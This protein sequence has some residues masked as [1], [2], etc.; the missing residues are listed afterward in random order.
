MQHE[1]GSDTGVIEIHREVP[2]LLYHPGPDRVL[3]GSENP[4]PAATVLDDDQ[5][6][7]LG[8]AQHAGGEEVQRQDR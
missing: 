5:D 3:R 2:G 6:V 1:S 8:A 4:S 7:H